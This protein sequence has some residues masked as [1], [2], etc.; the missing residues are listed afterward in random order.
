MG[1]GGMA[2]RLRCA[3]RKFWPWLVLALTVV[4]AVWH[5]LDF[6]E[7]VDPE[8]PSVE[9]L[10]FSRFPAAA[11]RLAEPGDTL[12]RIMIYVSALSVVSAA[13][14]LIVSRPKALWPA[15]L[16]IGIAALW[17]SATPGPTVDGWHGLGWRTILDK[18]APIGV[19][20]PLLIG[21]LVLVSVVAVTIHGH[22]QQLGEYWDRTRVKKTRS[23]WVAA[24][25]LCLARQVEIPG[26]GPEGY[27][28]RWA[29]IW[30]LIALDLGI[31]VELAYALRSKRHLLRAIPLALATWVAIV[32]AAV[33]L[34]WL[35]RPLARLRVVAPG[36]I[37]I[38]AMP[39]KR[40]LELSQRRHPFRTIINL[41]PED[42]AQRSP[43]L[44]DELRFAREHGIQ[45]VGS[46]SDPSE[47]ASSRISGQDAG[48]GAGSDRLADSGPLS[49][50]HGP[51]AGLDGDLSVRRRTK[52]SAGD[53]ARNRAAPWLSAQGIGHLALQPRV[54]APCRFA[55]PGRPHCGDSAAVCR[56]NNRPDHCIASPRI[57]YN[58]PRRQ[59]PC[60]HQGAVR[61]TELDTFAGGDR[62]RTH[63]HRLAFSAGKSQR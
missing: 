38:S 30:G 60:H 18:S 55:V 51:I 56:R 63:M 4:P 59:R 3:G 8:F 11:Y 27:W 34:S 2:T 21:A 23:I 35:H 58:E 1:N 47:A 24:L 40:G 10:T 62:V 14:G 57:D 49:W 42:T 17:Y 15:A 61:P 16:A 20:L 25:V 7:D 53:H 31:V 52:A 46:P 50:L 9:R 36:R 41:F 29:M 37:Y 39:T 12:D 54:A 33:W 28:P 44:P 5:V 22:R 48:P 6:D 45:Y 43:L 26:I 19:R 32:F 13:A